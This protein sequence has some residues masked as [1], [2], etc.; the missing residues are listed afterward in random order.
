MNA[1]VSAAA[2]ATGKKMSSADFSQYVMSITD[3]YEVV[4]MN[5][6]YMPK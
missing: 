2:L 6:F 3:L 1:Q 5:G 4:I